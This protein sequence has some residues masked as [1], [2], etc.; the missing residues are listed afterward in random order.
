M[1]VNDKAVRSVAKGTAVTF[2]A[3]SEDYLGDVYFLWYISENATHTG[4]GSDG[5]KFSYTFQQ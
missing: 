3:V 4:I 5:Q 2:T 1:T